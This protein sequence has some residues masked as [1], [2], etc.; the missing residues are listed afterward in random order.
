MISG[1]DVVNSLLSPL[2]TSK[3]VDKTALYS[4]NEKLNFVKKPKI[5]HDPT[6]PP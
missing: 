5:K 4:V 1:S 3:E 2:N 6:I